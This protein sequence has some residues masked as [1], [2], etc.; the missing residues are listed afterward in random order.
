[1]SRGLDDMLTYEVAI[2]F[3]FPTHTPNPLSLCILILPYKGFH[4]YGFTDSNG[5]FMEVSLLT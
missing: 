3:S 1:M 5:R 4:I 2:N